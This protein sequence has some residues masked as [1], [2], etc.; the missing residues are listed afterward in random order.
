[1]LPEDVIHEQ[2]ISCFARIFGFKNLI[3]KENKSILLDNGK[4]ERHDS[5]PRKPPRDFTKNYILNTSL[6]VP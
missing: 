5:Q 2:L 1:M 3:L 6:E 4:S